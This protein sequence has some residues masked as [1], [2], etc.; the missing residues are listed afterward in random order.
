MATITLSDMEDKLL[1]IDQV[2]QRLEATEPLSN[3]PLDSETRVRFQ[4]Q[5]DWAHA[6]DT[7]SD[8]QPVPV[9][10]TINGVDRQMTKEAILQAGANFGLPAPYMKK[11]P[12]RFAQGLLNHHYSADLGGTKTFNTLAVGDTISAFTRPT[13]VPF[14]NLQLLENAVNGIKDLHGSDAPVYADYKFHNSLQRTDIRLIVP[15]QERIMTGTDMDDVPD[16]QEDTWLAGIHLGNSLIGKGQTSIEAYM[17]RWWCTNGATTNFEGLGN[18]SRRSG[19]QDESE[20]YE[21]A[22]QSV[23]EVLGGME[24]M[25]DQVQALSSLNVNGAT[26]EVLREIFQQYEVPVSQ[27]EAIMERL[28][29]MNTLTM[30]SIMAAISEA[31]NE[32]GLEDRR[33]DRLMRIGGALPTTTFDTLKARIWREGHTANP[34]SRNPYEPLVIAGQLG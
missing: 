3:I 14:S 6:L 4:L 29:S 25:F 20:V 1:T 9:T 19:G 22:R 34:D 10:M 32:A 18:W 28:L 31:A 17:F 11:L 5:D 15:T 26:G 8:T 27:R 21:W 23:N 30:Y 33:R 16:G 12:S 2:T 13:L 7:V 24:H